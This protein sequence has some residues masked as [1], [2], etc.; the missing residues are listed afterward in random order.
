MAVRLGVSSQEQN[1]EENEVGKGKE[2]E[3][4]EG[5]VASNKTREDKTAIN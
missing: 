3:I 2:G 5:V 4:E 1:S